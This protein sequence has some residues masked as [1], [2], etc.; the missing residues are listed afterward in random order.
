MRHAC[1][2]FKTNRLANPLE[3]LTVTAMAIIHCM[4]QLMHKRI[5]KRNGII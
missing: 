2:P 3:I 4:A 1:R 5:E